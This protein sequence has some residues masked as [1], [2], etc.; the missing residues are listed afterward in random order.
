[1]FRS[2]YPHCHC[3]YVQVIVTPLS[4]FLI[5]S[6]FRS[7]YQ[8]ASQFRSLYPHC[9]CQCVQIIVPPLSL[10]VCS[11]HCT[12]TVTVS[13]FRSLYH[14]CHCS[15]YCLYL[16]V[17]VPN[18]LSVQIIVPPLSLSVSCSDHCTPTVTV[19][20]FR[21][22][23]PHCHG[24]YVQIIVPPLSLSVCSDRCTTT[25]TVSMFRSLYH[26]CHCSPY[27]LYLQVIVPTASQFR[28]LQ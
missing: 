5:L 24:K 9:H 27:C 15:T 6:I 11:D 10:S 16:Q 1:M 4:L 19:S 22:L 17:I 13:M 3:Q 25:V 28:S 14:H 18:C 7:L 2:L 12:T 21:S 8:T 23:Y 20:M 26:H